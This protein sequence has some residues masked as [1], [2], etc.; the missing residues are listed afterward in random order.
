MSG[1][2]GCPTEAYLPAS[3]I[4][5]PEAT[6]EGLSLMLST[7]ITLFEMITLGEYESGL[8]HPFWLHD[9][10]DAKGGDRIEFQYCLK[11]NPGFKWQMSG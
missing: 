3:G 1:E 6:A 4:N 9:F 8:T 2:R 5:L 7:T 11:G 10:S